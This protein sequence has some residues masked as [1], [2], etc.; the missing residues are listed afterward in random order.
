MACPALS[1]LSCTLDAR[2][3]RVEQGSGR[4]RVK[5]AVASTLYRVPRSTIYRWLSDQRLTADQH[6]RVALI[7]V[8][9]L[10][11]M[12]IRQPVDRLRLPATQ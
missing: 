8:E 11:E 12:R 1:G 6:G 10:A 5:V 3:C 2:A 4:V 7:E 9:Q